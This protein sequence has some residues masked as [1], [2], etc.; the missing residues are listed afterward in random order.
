MC[1]VPL[2]CHPCLSVLSETST[3]EGFSD[4]CYLRISK[5][6]TRAFRYV[7][8]SLKKYIKKRTV[9]VLRPRMFSVNA[10]STSGKEQS[11]KSCP[12]RMASLNAEM[13]KR[14]NGTP[15]HM[16][17]W[18]LALACSGTL[19]IELFDVSQSLWLKALIYWE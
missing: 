12:W 13:H 1:V 14:E 17:D 10:I 3:W 4:N 15:V 18:K 6:Q 7:W 11:V 2:F 19:F 5:A 8:W 16:L 9:N